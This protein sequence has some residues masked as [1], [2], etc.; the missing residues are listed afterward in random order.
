MAFSSCMCV[1]PELQAASKNAGE[2]SSSIVVITV[3]GMPT[4]Q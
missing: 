4:R 2:V 1:A 3:P